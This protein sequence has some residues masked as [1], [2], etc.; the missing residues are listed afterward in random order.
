VVYAWRK[1][2]SMFSIL[3]GYPLTYPLIKENRLLLRPLSSVPI[4]ISRLFASSVPSLWIYR[5]EIARCWWLM[6]VILA[7]QEA[8]IR[9]IVVRSQSGKIV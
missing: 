3:L 9:R 1:A 6:P 7:T 2:V 5:T 4:G 8:K